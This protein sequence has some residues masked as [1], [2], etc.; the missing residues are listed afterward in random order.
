MS[1]RTLP[2][3]RLRRSVVLSL[4]AVLSIAVSVPTVTAGAT[5]DTLD[6]QNRR[7][8]V[9]VQK[10]IDAGGP[11]VVVRV[12][13]GRGRLTEIARQAAWT[14]PDNHLS[15]DDQFRMGSNTKTMVATVILQLVAE[16]RLRLNDPVEKWLPGLVVNGRAITV[17]MLLNHTSGLAEYVV[18]PAVLA[19]ITGQQQRTWTPQ[20]LLAIAAQYPALFP[21]GQEH[22][23]S[24]TNY[25]ALG[26]VLERATGRSVATLI[27]E[28]IVRPLGLRHTYL[29][30]DSASRDGDKLAHAY[31]PDAAH[32]APLLPPGTPPGV[33]FVGPARGEHIDTTAI[34]PSWAWAGG[35]MVSTPRDWTHFLSA[36]MSGRL[37]PAAQLAEMRTFVEDPTSAGAVQYGLGLQQYTNP[38]GTVWGHTGGIP[39]Y[40]SQ[41]YTDNTGRRTVSVV[42]TTQFG[43]RDPQLGTADQNVVDAAICVMLGKPIPAN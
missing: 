32:L 14:R 6:R 34:N 3:Y 8:N 43:L 31:E 9:L 26:L 42:S 21:P 30:T 15:V 5:P 10:D 40:S 11:G 17:R 24:N 35:A 37:I 12:D 36:L 2:S 20:Q 39:G 27:H 33:A 13:N 25:V 22:Y 4:A 38:C 28:R 23:Y 29:A 16:R 7:L 18:D 1:D 41:N 19:A